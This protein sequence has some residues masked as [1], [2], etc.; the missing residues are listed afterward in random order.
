M[1]YRRGR[2]PYWLT[3]K[4]AGKCAKCGKVISAGER[5]YYYPNTRT[6]YCGG[7]DCGGAAARD[8]SACAMDEAQYNGRW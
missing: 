2:D 5:I 8:F 6:V 3:A 7:D 4:Y 1:A